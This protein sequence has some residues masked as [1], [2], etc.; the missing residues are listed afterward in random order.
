MVTRNIFLPNEGTMEAL[1]RAVAA[2]SRAGDTIL[3]EGPL[4]VG[5]STFARAYIRARADDPELIVPSPS[6]TLVQTYG[7]VPPVTHADLWR[8]QN[9]ADALELGLD[10]AAAGGILLIEWPDRLNDHLPDGYLK[11]S[12]LWDGEKGRRAHLEGPARLVEVLPE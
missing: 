10:E 9:A 1:A 12:L 3:L 7:L 8:I 4:G 5:K 2:R 6:F 11:I